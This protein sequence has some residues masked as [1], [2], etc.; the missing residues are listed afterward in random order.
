MKQFNKTLRA[1][2]RAWDKGCQHESWSARC[3]SFATEPLP[4]WYLAKLY[5]SL[6]LCDDFVHGE[7]SFTVPM[8]GDRNDRWEIEVQDRILA[9]LG[10][11]R[12]REKTGT[13][14]VADEVSG[15]ST[16]MNS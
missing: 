9:W 1:W 8:K 15:I 12:G 5:Q 14:E 10:D 4:F 13:N 7:I 2:R 16:L 11:F 3:R 6:Y